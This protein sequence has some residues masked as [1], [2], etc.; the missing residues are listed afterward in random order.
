MKKLKTA[1]V[2]LGV[3]GRLRKDWIEKNNNYKIIAISDTRFKNDFK[4]KDIFYYQDFKKILSLNLDCVFVTLPNYLAP[5]VTRKFLKKNISV[6]CEKPPGRNVTDIKNVI[7]V[8]KK[9]L[10]KLKYGFNHRYHGSVKLAK[11]YIQS[12]ELGKILNI[13]GL[14]GKSKIISYEKSDWRSK[15]KFAGGGI[16]LD[17]GIHMLDLINFFSGPFTV[18][19]SLV[20]YNFWKY[21]V[22]DDVFAIMRSKKNV[23]ASIHSTAIQ[24]Q[25]RFRLEI[26]LEKGS[27]ELNGILSGSKSYGRESISISKV[28]TKKYKN[29]IER[30]VI[31]FKKDY[32]WKEEISDFANIIKYNKKIYSGN[33][34]EALEVMKMIGRIYKNDK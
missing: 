34:N 4:K 21:D 28:K 5:I 23:M 25:H 30:K 9:S 10:G 26:N 16:L 22:E 12:S 33:S 18:Y 15:K 3:V 27:L 13:R 20:S 32:S 6:F 17:Q 19:K 8:E 2:G 29:K 14:Y 1:I 11:K 31:Y 24:W 7:K